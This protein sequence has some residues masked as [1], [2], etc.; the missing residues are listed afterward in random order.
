MYSI[1]TWI[2][3]E[4]WT[5]FISSSRFGLRLETKILAGRL[6]PRSGC[7]RYQLN[8]ML[9]PPAPMMNAS[10][11][12][13]SQ[14]FSG[15]N[16]SSVPPAEMGSFAVPTSRPPDFDIALTSPIRAANASSSSNTS[17][18]ACRR[19]ILCVVTRAPT[20]RGSSLMKRT[21]FR[22]RSGSSC[23]AMSMPTS[24]Q[25]PSCRASAHRGKTRMIIDV[26]VCTPMKYIVGRTAAS[27]LS[28]RRSVV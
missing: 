26:F 25:F 18:A 16:A 9:D 22:Y 17:L 13:R 20:E 12:V 2:P 5:F 28:G 3:C 1:G 23:S 27:S 8:A 21:T 7:A 15:R 6:F 19:S 11:L 10:A 14:C 4:S 24:W